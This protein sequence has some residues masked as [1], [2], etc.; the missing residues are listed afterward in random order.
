MTKKVGRPVANRFKVPK[1]QWDRWS[2]AAQKMFNHLFQSM[3]PSRQFV[4]M[5]PQAL[6]IDRK[7]WDTIRWN[8]AWEAACAI[9]GDS[10]VAKMLGSK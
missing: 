2:V 3:R 8:A 6:P 5:H 7:H 10:H 9:D 1:K 4:F